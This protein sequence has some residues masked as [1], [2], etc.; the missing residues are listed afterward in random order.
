MLAFQE[1]GTDGSLFQLDIDMLSSINHIN[2]VGL[3]AICTETSPKY[4]L[5]EAGLPGD[6]LTHVREMKNTALPEVAYK[7][8][9]KELLRIAEQISVGM[10]YLTSERFVHKD[11][12]LRNCC[13]CQDGVVKITYFGLGPGLYPE[14]YCRID[15]ADL[16]IR[17]MPP[18]AVTSKHFTSMSDV[19]SFGVTVWEIFTYGDLPFANW[20]NEELLDLLVHRGERLKKPT[21]CSDYIF[22][23]LL[24]CWTTEVHSRPSFLE[25]HERLMEL[26]K[27]QSFMSGLQ[28]AIPISPSSTMTSI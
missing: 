12:A 5:L 17:W 25:I 21:G 6:L 23:M 8:E 27:I 20:S 4:I 22:D 19:W 2:V 3:L 24:S 11:L 10:T 7:L 9:D 26:D 14:A 28:S 16:P 1:E 18:E 15:K 13:I